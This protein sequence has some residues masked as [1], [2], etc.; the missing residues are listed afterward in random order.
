MRYLPIPGGDALAGSARATQ[1]VINPA[2]RRLPFDDELYRSVFGPGEAEGHA[3]LLEY[4]DTA[5]QDHAVLAQLTSEAGAGNARQLISIA[6]RLA[7]SS[8]SAGAIQ[9]GDAAKAVEQAALGGNEAELP[10]L[11][12][13]LD[14]CF[15]GAEAA[16]L[17]FIAADQRLAVTID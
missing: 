2:V 13:A 14:A 6:H 3:W 9:F 1:P 4:L 16:I 7:G 10:D 11:L 17:A 5:R 8:F 15:I 12:T